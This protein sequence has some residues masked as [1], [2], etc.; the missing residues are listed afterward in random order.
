M[1]SALDDVRSGVATLEAQCHELA[2]LIDACDWNGFQ[3]LLSDM[4]RVRHAVANAWDAAKDKRTP[5]FEREIVGRVQRILEYRQY[6]LGRLDQYR[7][8]TGERLK[9]MSRWRSYARSVASKRG[10]AKAALFS[11]IR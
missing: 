9:L 2:P 11:D 8:E 1:A 3:R 7:G 5:E 10:P 4:G 6:Q